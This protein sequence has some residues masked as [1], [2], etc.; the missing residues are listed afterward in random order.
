[1]TAVVG[2]TTK[3]RQALR[4]LAGAAVGAVATIAFL[5]AV[6]KPSLKSGDF[7]TLLALS[8]GLI[9]ALMGLFVGLGAMAPRQG[10]RFLNV[11]DAEEIHE[12]RPSLGS[13]AI[14]C[15]LIGAFLLLLALAPAGQDADR[16]VW[17]GAAG[18]CLLGAAA[19]TL[20][21]R[22]RGDELMRQ[23]GLEASSLTLH[24]T[25][26]VLSVWAL[27]AQL[28]F[29]EWLT[30]LGLISGLSLLYLAAIFW[31]TARKG[32]MKAR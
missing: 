24:V 3:G 15:I 8:A 17:A 16:G 5:E 7:G 4:M 19:I 31:V 30:P 21:T 11:E 6:G 18:A 1:M 12:Q 2:K 32:M 23:V 20:A 26:A 13:S 10:A 27:L 9:Y 14:A 25:L 29:V 22:R 28:R